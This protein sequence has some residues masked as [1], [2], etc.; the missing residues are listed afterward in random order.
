MS[1]RIRAARTSMHRFGCDMPR[2][3]RDE[4]P[5]PL[6]AVAGVRD[7][8]AK[9]ADYLSADS[10]TVVTDRGR[11]VAVLVRLPASYWNR[12]PSD[13]LLKRL[14]EATADVMRKYGL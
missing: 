10:P 5:A 3:R 7:L 6:P 13:A 12:Y 11:C 2:T 14:Q 8:R 9:L 1:E 4:K